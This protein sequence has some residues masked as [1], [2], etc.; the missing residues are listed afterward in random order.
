M[1]TS[2]Q[3]HQ[4]QHQKLPTIIFTHEDGRIITLFNGAEEVLPVPIPRRQQQE[5]YRGHGGPQFTAPKKSVERTIGELETQATTVQARQEMG[6]AEE[7]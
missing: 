2:P 6:L 3:S 1:S 7:V 5:Q 4:N